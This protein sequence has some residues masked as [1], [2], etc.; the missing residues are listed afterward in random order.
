MKKIN[1]GVRV[2]IGAG[3]FAIAL[4]ILTRKYDPTSSIVIAGIG[5][6]VTMMIM[7]LF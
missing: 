4:Y 6:L 7:E 1:P 3:V 2:L 5:T